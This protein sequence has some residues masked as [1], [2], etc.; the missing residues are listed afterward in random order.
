MEVIKA[1][2]KQ[3][4]KRKLVVS[5]LCE[6]KICD[7]NNIVNTLELGID[8]ID[9]KD[10]W[11]AQSEL[12]TSENEDIAVVFHFILFWFCRLICMM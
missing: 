6:E 7:I 5:Q 11:K 1:Y 12:F 9:F 8:K 4:P 10:C 2:S 3:F